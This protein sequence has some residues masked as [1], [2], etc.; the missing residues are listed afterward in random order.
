MK[1]GSF[2]TFL[3]SHVK[4]NGSQSVCLRVT[5]LRKTKFYTLPF[6]VNPTMWNAKKCRIKGNSMQ[7]RDYNN[8]I[9]AYELDAH[10]IL[11]D[12]NI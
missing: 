11:F 5:I 10:K 3:R 1:N 9:E 7:I 4:N 6:N 8:I 2:K 12:A